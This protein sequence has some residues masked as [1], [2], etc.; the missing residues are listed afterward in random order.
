MQVASRFVIVAFLKFVHT[1]TD[2]GRGVE[3][4]A[5][6]TDSH[7][8]LGNFCTLSVTQTSSPGLLPYLDQ[9]PDKRAGSAGPSTPPSFG[10]GETG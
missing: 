9:Q 5:V 6:R 8:V 3:V 2:W 4:G 1:F 10:C 7:L